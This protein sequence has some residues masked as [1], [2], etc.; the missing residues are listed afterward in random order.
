MLNL[1]R[2]FLRLV[3]FFHSNRAE[4]DLAREIDAHLRLL[5]DEFM[6]RGMNAAEARDAARRAFGGVEQAKERQRDARSFRW[7][8]GWSMDLRLSARM[9]VKYPGLTLVGGVTMA[10]AIAIG[11]AGFEL[12]TQLIVPTLPLSSGDRIIGIRIRDAAANAEERRASFDFQGLREQIHAIDQI[13]AFRNVERNLI[14]D[15]AGGEP[16]DVAEMTASGFRVAGVPAVLGRSLVDADQ[17]PGAPPVVVIGD[18]IWQRRFHGDPN[19]VG[20][21]VRLDRTPHLIVGVMPAGFRFPVAHSVWTPLRLDAAVAP[22]A[23]PAIQ[24]FGRLAPGVTMSEARTAVE[25]FGRRT[26]DASPATHAQLRPELVRYAR[27]LLDLQEASQGSVAMNVF[28]VMFLVLVCGNVAALVFARAVSRQ[29]E[30][31]VRTALGASRA[32][33]VGQLFA[34]TL[35]LGGLAAAAGLGGAVFLLRWL[36]DVYQ[37]ESG[38]R[39]PFWL[40]ANLSPATVL[41]TAVLTILGAAIAGV[42]PA[43]KLTGQRLEGLLREATTCGTNHR[44]GGIWTFVIVSQVAVTVAFP[45]TAFFARRH[46]VGVRSLDPGV[47]SHQYLSARIV[48]DAEQPNAV[49]LRFVELERRLSAEPEVSGVTFATRLPRMSHPARRVEIDGVDTQQH[50]S[51]AAVA[52]NYFDVLQAPILAGRAF[53][54]ADARAGASRNVIVNESFVRRALGGRNPIGR[55][56]RYASS[57]N[58]EASPWFDIVGLV[59]DLGTIHDDHTNSAALYHPLTTRSGAEV[60]IAIHL[61]GSPEAY[62]P[63]LRSIATAVDPGLKL[64]EVSPLDRTGTSLWLEMN[65]LYKLLTFVSLT[66]V[67]LSLAGIYSVLSFGVSRRTREIGI[68]IALGATAARI[69]GSIFSRALAQVGAGILMGGVLVLLLTLAVTGLS[70]AELVVIVGYMALMLAVCSIASFVPIRRALRVEPT[71]ALRTE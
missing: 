12:L 11:A 8:A 27:S 49:P 43:L 28:A 51:V 4:D 24:M 39:L 31:V 55:Q 29:T 20:R 21:L 22:R 65:F 52:A 19:V 17:E 42:L 3:T 2:F 23:G 54:A 33:L 68:R 64:T 48:A 36:M 56:V 7:L 9:L 38:G 5:E 50:A 18:D 34:E 14:V 61:K 26:A 25:A 47:P 44:F 63:R 6:S 45:A 69:V 32:R 41:Y 57:Q 67:V 70:A 58:T 71:E 59:K 30:I 60:H 53:T 16:V 13:G 10:V 35:M 66:A 1:R 40:D 62:V 15:G 37:A 46:V